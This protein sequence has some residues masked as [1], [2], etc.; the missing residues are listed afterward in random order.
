MSSSRDLRLRLV[1]QILIEV[2][3]GLVGEEV[4]GVAGAV[5]LVPVLRLRVVEPQ[6]HAVFRARGG[7]LLEHVAL[8]RRGVDDVVRADLRVVERE[9]VVMLR[10]DD[11]V[12]HARVFRELHPLVG[13]ELDRIELPGELLVFLH[14]DLRAVHDPLADAG[15]AAAFPLAGGNRVEPPVNEEAVL[16]LVEPLEAFR[17]CGVRAPSTR[18]STASRSSIVAQGERSLR[19]AL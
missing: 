2:L 3:L 18:C 11:D 13:V 14:R 12:F 9:A 4:P 6:A 17:L 7:E 15:N 5:R 1:A 19:S 8:E 16:R 10:G